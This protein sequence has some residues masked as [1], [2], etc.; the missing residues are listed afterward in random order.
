[1]QFV[2]V[3]TSLEHQA[4]NWKNGHPIPGRTV[5]F[6]MLKVGTVPENPKRMVT[7]MF[8][9]AKNALNFDDVRII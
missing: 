3:G 6:G 9:D 4:K 2:N 8:A 1:V 7:L 5:I